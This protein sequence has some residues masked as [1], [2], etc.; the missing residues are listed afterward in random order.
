MALD[1]YLKLENID[2]EST[3]QGFEK[4]INLLSFSWGGSQVTSVTGT[5][6]SGAGRAN[7]H[8][9][10]IQKFMDKSSTKLWKALLA[11]THIK[12]GKISVCKAAGDTTMNKPFFTIDLKEVFVTDYSASESGEIPTESVTFS[13][14]DIKQE[15]FQ[16]DEAGNLTSTGAVTYNLKEHKLS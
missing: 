14:N 9:I 5:G 3:R 4:H 12:T 8:P 2:G 16:Q 7:V 11:G 15:Y 13:Y 6:G 1:A 10:T